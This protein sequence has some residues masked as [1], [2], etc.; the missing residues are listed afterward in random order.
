MSDIV[1]S[2]EI[3]QIVGAYR[4][5][6]L[7]IGR[8]VTSEDRVYILHSVE[9]RQAHPD[10]RECAMSRALDLGV[11]LDDWRDATDRP[12][13]LGLSDRARLVPADKSVTWMW[14]RAVTVQHIL[15][16]LAKGAE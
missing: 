13:V 16:V 9:C 8:V 2:D 11:D 4:D 7:H 3:E 5:R 12:M 15:D 1:S 6:T 14:S 10:L